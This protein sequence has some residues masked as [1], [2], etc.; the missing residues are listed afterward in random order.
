MLR[1]LTLLRATRISSVCAVAGLSVAELV[2]MGPARAS[3]L[4]PEPLS[5]F[6]QSVL[7]IR[8]LAGHVTNFKVWIA[9]T[10][11]RDEQGLMYVKSLDEHAGMLFVFPDLQRVSMWMKN[12]YV[13]LDMVFID[14]SGHVDYIAPR[15]TPLSLDII[16][17]PRPERA[18][19]ELKGGDCDAFG[20][21]TGD[22]VFDSHL[23][24]GR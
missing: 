14:A 23:P 21:H 4:D 7:A 2:A 15:A 22:Q 24:A 6:P 19:L 11:S 1:P 18:V 5:A 3:V 8:S 20:I 17:A 9:D 10:P 13:S 12:T 16:S